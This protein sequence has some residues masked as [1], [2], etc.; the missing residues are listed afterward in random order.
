MY[1][2]HTTILEMTG[3]GK[4][5][6]MYKSRNCSKE[7]EQHKRTLEV[8]GFWHPDIALAVMSPFQLLPEIFNGFV[9]TRE[10]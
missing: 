1:L 4:T 2:H 9:E 5:H 6:H 7:C 3:L 10:H 8:F